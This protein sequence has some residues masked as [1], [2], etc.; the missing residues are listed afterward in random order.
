MFSC[1]V[2]TV[3]FYHRN[4][5]PHLRFVKISTWQM[6]GMGGAENRRVLA[7]EAAAVPGIGLAVGDLGL[8]AGLPSRVCFALP[9]PGGAILSSGSGP[10]VE[11][12]EAELTPDM[13]E[14]ESPLRLRERTRL[15]WIWNRL[16]SSF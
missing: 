16:V 11:P 6:S 3:L 8:V 7:V 2:W 13:A 10:R 1:S 5:F 12:P 4:Y 9:S 15:C 14:T